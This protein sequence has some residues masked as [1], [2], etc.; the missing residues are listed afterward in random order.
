MNLNEEI[1]FDEK[2]RK[3]S[4]AEKKR[5]ANYKKEEDRMINEGYEKH[6]FTVSI[7][8]A[9]MYSFVV[10]LPFIALFVLLYFLVG[11]E[12]VITNEW[13]AVVI[14]VLNLIAGTF[15]HEGLHGLGYAP[16]A[17]NHF[18]DIEFGFI[19]EMLTPYCVCNCLLRKHQYLIGLLM[20][21]FVL[22]V[23][24]SI[25]GI[26]FGNLALLISGAFQIICAGG[27]LLVAYLVIWN[28]S[29]KKDALY[30]DHPTE[31]GVVMFD[32]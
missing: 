29:K 3:L 1:E 21:F 14:F 2:K 5:L 25:I 28:K 11:N 15:V 16:S 26:V 12:F 4:K 32:K 31:C 17:K 10:G 19:P 22:G 13:V 18:K 27:D 9:N 7:V 23:C 8:Q 24:V 30:Y 6:E 20:P